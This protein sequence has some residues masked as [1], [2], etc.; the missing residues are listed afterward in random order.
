[1]EKNQQSYI[2]ESRR[3]KVVTWVDQ[4]SKYSY[5]N[6]NEFSG[7]LAVLLTCATDWSFISHP[8]ARHRVSWES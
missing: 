8:Y 7:W 1:L 4:I 2:S 6:L 3:A 5:S